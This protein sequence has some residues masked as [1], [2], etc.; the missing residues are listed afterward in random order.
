MVDGDVPD[1]EG[2]EHPRELAR[3]VVAV[4]GQDQPAAFARQRQHE[5]ERRRLARGERERRGILERSER[6]LSV[7]QV[8]FPS[9]PY[10]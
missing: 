10:A 9:R 1:T 7:S 8:A 4:V 6:G 3:A 2:R 5:R